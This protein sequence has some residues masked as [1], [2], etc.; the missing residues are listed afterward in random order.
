MFERCTF[1]RNHGYYGG[2]ISSPQGGDWT[3]KDTTFDG[4]WASQG[5]GGGAIKMDGGHCHWAFIRC[6]FTTDSNP[7]SSDVLVP[8]QVASHG[9][10]ATLELFNSTW[11]DNVDTPGRSS[12][13]INLM[14]STSTVTFWC[15]S[16]PAGSRCRTTARGA[17]TT[18]PTRAENA[19][20][21]AR[22]PELSSLFASNFYVVDVVV[23][24][25]PQRPRSCNE[26]G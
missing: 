12:T 10:P 4:N 11:P 18:T 22:A 13:Y 15:T 1:R 3:F 17:C 8:G 6:N 19:R 9:E 7:L 25:T 26:R 5:Y 2:A 20:R 23:P 16:P 14:D 21:I 24:V